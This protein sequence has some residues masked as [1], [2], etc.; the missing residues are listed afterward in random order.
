MKQYYQKYNAHNK[1]EQL[2]RS[3]CA[4]EM[5][6]FM[7]AAVDS[8]TCIR[9]SAA[10]TILNR[11]ESVDIVNIASLLRYSFLSTLCMH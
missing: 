1:D 11:S 3:L 6:S 10:T 4:L 7:I 9:R 5:N 2:D 8:K